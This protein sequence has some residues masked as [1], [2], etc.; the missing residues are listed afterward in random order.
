M[1]DLNPIE[2][3]YAHPTNN[4][5]NDLDTVVIALCGCAIIVVAKVLL[6]L[7]IIAI[8]QLMW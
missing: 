1:S 8:L 5:K 6:L 3:D 7:L 2:R 4:V